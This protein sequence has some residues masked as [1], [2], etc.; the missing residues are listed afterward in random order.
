V[1]LSQDTLTGASVEMLRQ[2][3]CLKILTAASAETIRKRR[4]LKILL[5]VHLQGG[6]VSVAVSIMFRYILNE[7]YL[8]QTVE[9]T[10]S[11]PE[12]TILLIRALTKKDE[13]NK[14]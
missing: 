1:S 8:F 12:R 5:R 2:C 13:K 6:Y 3:R 7:I 14:K 11:D 9:D 4:C 10:P